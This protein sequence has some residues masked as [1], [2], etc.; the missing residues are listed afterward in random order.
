MLKIDS[1][2]LTARQLHELGPLLPTCTTYSPNHTIELNPARCP[3]RDAL[4]AWLAAVAPLY[5]YDGTVVPVDE[6]HIRRGRPCRARSCALALAL[7]DATGEHWDVTSSH[8]S[9]FPTAARTW[10]IPYTL[11]TGARAFLS[12][13]DRDPKRLIPPATFV[14]RMSGTSQ[15]SRGPRPTLGLYQPE[16]DPRHA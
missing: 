1:T 2:R 6:H 5:W 15:R 16:C 11:S 10:Y 13:F 8:C 14:L 12:R 4:I 3:S 7:H 9:T